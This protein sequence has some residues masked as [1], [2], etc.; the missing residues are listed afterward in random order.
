MLYPSESTLIEAAKIMSE[1]KGRLLVF[2][3]G[4]L[5]G[6]V[7]VTD[8]VRKIHSSGKAFGFE[9]TYS[10]KI[11]EEVPEA[12]LERIVRLMVKRRIGSIIISGGKLPRGIFTERDLLRALLTEVSI[13]IRL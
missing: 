6:I 1:K 9:K 8:I 2:D 7:T 11:C 10:G 5:I 12:K 4:N 3:D 13:W